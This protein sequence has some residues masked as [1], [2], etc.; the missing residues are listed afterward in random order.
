[1][2][3]VLGDVRGNR[4]QLRDLM[5]ARFADTMPCG[6]AVR[7]V[8]TGVRHELDERIH[9]LRRHQLTMMPGMPRL[10]AGGASTLHATTTL[11][12]LTREAIG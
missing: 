3:A 10:T 1:M 8:P 12:L 2:A 4:R 11:T 9:A 5:P 7:A 6:Q